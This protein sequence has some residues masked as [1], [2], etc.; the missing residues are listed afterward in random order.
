MSDTEQNPYQAP[1]ADITV[2]TE[3]GSDTLLEK[4]NLVSAGKGIDWVDRSIKQTLAPQLNIW[5]V[6]GLI[7]VV[8]SLI[9]EHIP[10]IN[11]IVPSLLAPIFSAG[12][13]LGADKIF[14]GEK[15]DVGQLFAGFTLPKTSHLFIVAVLTLVSIIIL[16]IIMFAII[17]F[18]N[19][20]AMLSGG[21]VT[22]E[23]LLGIMTKKIW[24]M[25]PVAIISGI[26]LALAFWFP[27]ILIAKHEISAFQAIAM[28]F[29]GGLKNI[30]T[31]I[32][33]FILLLIVGFILGFLLTLVVS[34]LPQFIAEIIGVAVAI[35]L[36][37]FWAG[38]TYHAYRDIFL[39]QEQSTN[40]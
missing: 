3:A 15:I 20:K 9:L 19:L 38:I 24:T 14:R 40:Q 33:L 34:L 11:A 35:P 22:P 18:D 27:P 23:A 1:E 21:Q 37:G 6:I 30:L 26:L 4:P 16:A 8:I 31:L 36:I 10:Y 39:G 25:I 13:V 7:Y 12:L 32:I 5:L 29:K 28:S 17:G 2:S